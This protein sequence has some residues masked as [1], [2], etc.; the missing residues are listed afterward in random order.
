MKRTAVWA[1]IAASADDCRNETVVLPRYEKV[2]VEYRNDD[3]NWDRDRRDS[4]EHVRV[5]RVRYNNDRHDRR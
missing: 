3:H 5:E 2:R 4:R 1:P